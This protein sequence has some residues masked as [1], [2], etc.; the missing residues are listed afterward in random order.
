MLQSYTLGVGITLEQ[1]HTLP[2]VTK[3]SVIRHT[4]KASKKNMKY[5][6]LLSFLLIIASCKNGED[7][8]KLNE[9]PIK[10]VQVKLKKSGLPLQTSVSFLSNLIHA[11]D[12]IYLVYEL[13][14]LNNFKAPLDLKKVEIFNLLEPEFPISTFDSIY[15]NENFERPGLSSENDLNLISENQFGILNLNLEFKKNNVIP[16]KVFH[17][18]HFKVQKGNGE[19]MMYSMETTII[20]IPG[21]TN[22]TLGLPFNKKGIWLYEAES[23]KNSRFL[24]EGRATYPQRFAIDWIYVNNNEELAKNNIKENENWHTYGLELVSVADGIV[25]D[26]KDDIIENEPLS[27]EMAVHI[28]K[29]TIGGNYVIIDI[30]N[31]I[32]AFYGHLIPHSLKVSIGNKV[33][34][35]QVIGLLGNS[36]NSDLPHLHF[37]LESKSNIFFGGEGMP[38]HIKEFIQLKGY[39]AE[40]VSNLFHSNHVALDSLRP[41]EKNNELPIGY[42]L[43]EVK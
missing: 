4:S 23:H 2:I 19:S 36:G 22:L 24:A 28:T 10:Q 32:Y 15:L 20:D 7:S 3:F 33:K 42:G 26:V 6:I 12:K 39:S 16:K 38:Y 18:L 41:I 25:V 9:K 40:E 35:G 29:E 31:D 37:H 27:E 13:N 11:N 21:K 34:K 30:G 43:I 8:K 1:I 17:K 5:T 14:I